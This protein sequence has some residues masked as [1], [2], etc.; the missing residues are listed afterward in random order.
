MLKNIQRKLCNETQ[1]NLARPLAATKK[2][3]Y[4]AGRGQAQ[5]ERMAAGDVGDSGDM[6]DTAIG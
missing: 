5:G 2:G 6:C 4:M 3:M 1:M